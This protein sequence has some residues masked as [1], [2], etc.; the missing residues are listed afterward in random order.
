MR[1][2]AL[3]SLLAAVAL[4]WSGA[5]AMTAEEMQRLRQ[6]GVSEANIQKMLELERLQGQDAVTEQDGQVIY[7]AGQGNAARRQANQAH[8]R[9]KEEKSLEAVGGMVIDARPD[10]A[11]QGSTQP[12]GATTGQ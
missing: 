1:F 10:A 4:A 3:I 9:W 2:I 8:E 6:A 5:A 12:Q 11:A 7:R